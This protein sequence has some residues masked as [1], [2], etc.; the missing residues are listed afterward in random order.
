MPIDVPSQ[1]VFVPVVTTVHRDVIAVDIAPSLVFDMVKSLKFLFKFVF[2]LLGLAV[3]MAS[4][5]R[6]PVAGNREVVD[7]DPHLA[8]A[9]PL[10]SHLMVFSVD[11]TSGSLA[12]HIV[13]AAP[14]LDLRVHAHAYLAYLWQLQ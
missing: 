3:S 7:A 5:V 10:L 6:H 2:A 4:S 12:A 8:Y 9:I 11:I 1:H 13:S 14:P